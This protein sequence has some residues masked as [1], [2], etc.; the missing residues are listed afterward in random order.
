M[1]LQMHLGKMLIDWHEVDFTGL[2]TV[3]EREDY[4]Q[5]I[6]NEMYWKHYTKIKMSVK[7][8]V[9]FIDRVES[10]MNYEKENF[11]YR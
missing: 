8:P 10:E 2:N 5:R 4:L 6:A 7:T 9:F 3:F 1:Y 11:N